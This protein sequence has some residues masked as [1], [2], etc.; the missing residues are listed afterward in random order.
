MIVSG[1][2]GLHA[3]AGYGVA[4]PATAPLG[5]D[6]GEH[7]GAVLIERVS[8]AGI[9]VTSA[10][11]VGVDP[12]ALGDLRLDVSGEQFRIAAVQAERLRSDA[13]HV[14]L[15]GL[16]LSPARRIA[17]L[18]QGL[19]RRGVVTPPAPVMPRVEYMRD[20]ARIHETL[21]ALVR[22]HC[23][24]STRDARGTGT[25][26]RL[27]ALGGPSGPLEFL[28]PLTGRGH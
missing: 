1:K 11:L 7:G 21:Y 22:N 3:D 10:R 9:V 6:L 28:G 26:G 20:A 16:T 27:H 23:E 5:A 12:R 14:V 19:V 2:A 15:T 8:P 13:F 17:G 24:C 25:T 4:D 18:L